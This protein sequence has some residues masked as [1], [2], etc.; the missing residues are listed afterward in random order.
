LVPSSIVVDLIGSNKGLN[1]SESFGKYDGGSVSFPAGT[2][3]PP[4]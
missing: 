2:S 1:E 3:T 4:P